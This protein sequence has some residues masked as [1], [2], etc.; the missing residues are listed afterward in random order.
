MI[1]WSRGIRRKEPQVV[2]EESIVQSNTILAKAT[3]A[4]IAGVAW[5]ALALQLFLMIRDSDPGGM[6]TL[7]AVVNYLS[8]FTILTN[9][10]VAV[11]LS[12]RFLFSESRLGRFFLRPAAQSATAVYIAVVGIIYALLLRHLW[13]PQGAQKLA[14][15]LLHDVVPVTYGLF[16]L[17]FVPKTTLRWRDSIQWLAYPVLYM[18]YTLV[19]GALSGWY[20]YYFIDVRA[21]GLPHVLKNASA[22]LVCFIFMAL[23]FVAVGRWVTRPAPE[24]T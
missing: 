16:W 9:L 17:V 23:I 5:F 24:T 7:H 14:D 20:P 15:V 1:P 21:I 11:G 22:M 6:A 8:F 18:A 13:N 10:L 3:M 2:R 4:A 19:H 12:F